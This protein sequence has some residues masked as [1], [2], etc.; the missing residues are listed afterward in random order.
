MEKVC[1]KMTKGQSESD[2]RFIE[3]EEKRMKLDYDMLKMEQEW[4]KEE[5]ERA[6]RRAREDKE[7]QLRVLQIMYPQSN[8]IFYPNPQ[9]YPNMD[10]PT[11]CSS[12]GCF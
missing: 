1:D 9:Y 6:E 12:Y 7:F 4:R 8:N 3:L 10:P 2:K 11:Y 5:A